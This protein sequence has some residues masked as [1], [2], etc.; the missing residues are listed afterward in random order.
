MLEI[1]KT[2]TNFTK[3]YIIPLLP[4]FCE[5]YKNK[6][7]QIFNNDHTILSASGEDKFKRIELYKLNVISNEIVNTLI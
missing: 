6:F 1:E 5:A 3:Q 4:G 2:Q 7:S